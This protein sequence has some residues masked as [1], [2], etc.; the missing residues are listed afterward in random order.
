ML[1]I[2]P[3]L[4]IA[5]NN[6]FRWNIGELI[7]LGLSLDAFFTIWITLFGII[8]LGFNIYINS[9]RLSKQDIQIKQQD[10]LLELQ[11][12]SNAADRFKNGVQLIG[13]DN[14]SVV[15]GGIFLLIEI[16]RHDT[17]NF[18]KQ[19]FEVLCAYLRTDTY[20]K[21][22]SNEE[23]NL[24]A[25]EKYIFPNKYQIVI[26]LLFRDKN[27]FFKNNIKDYQIKLNNCCFINA[28]LR[29]AFLDGAIFKESV[30]INSNFEEAQLYGSIFKNVNAIATDFCYANLRKSSVLNF[31]AD[32]ANFYGVNFEG[33]FFTGIK[34]NG[35]YFAYSHLEGVQ[36]TNAKFCGVSFFNTYFEGA[37]LNDIDFSLSEF[38]KA[39][40][41]G[42]GFKNIDFRN[43]SISNMPVKGGGEYDFNK[44]RLL[45]D[46]SLENFK[47]R[48]GKSTII[49]KQIKSTIIFGRLKK[50]QIDSCLSILSNPKIKPKFFDN[51]LESIM[52]RRYTV[53]DVN[54]L[55]IG[56]L[57]TKE[58]KEIMDRVLNPEKNRE[59][60]QVAIIKDFR[61][62]QK[63][64]I[65]LKT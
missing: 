44:N 13:S 64:Y 25:I 5:F 29:K 33:A 32:Y 24:N 18:A 2:S 6:L 17:K 57:T 56:E 63:M 20:K 21:W 51:G 27:Q 19:V 54:N 49:E 62:V 37:I 39:R 41:Q 65:D 3:F 7:T 50:E 15:I 30:L 40:M 61:N 9:E 58:G 46:T 26:D 43:A 8:G 35:A 45:H 48:I 55:L 31:K 10:S 14:D 12:K 42:V 16:A 1:F 38:H 4:G 60:S 11:Q 52:Q 53:S 22:K 36:I 59:N 23:N 47:Q 34:A 28:D